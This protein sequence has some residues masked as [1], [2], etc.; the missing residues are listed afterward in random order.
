[1][2]SASKRYI[3][4]LFKRKQRASD[5]R[6]T[7]VCSAAPFRIAVV[8]GTGITC[9]YVAVKSSLIYVICWRNVVTHWLTC[10]RCCIDVWICI[11]RQYIQGWNLPRYAGVTSITVVD[12]KSNNLCI[13]KS[14]FAD[15]PYTKSVIIGVSLAKHQKVVVLCPNF[16]IFETFSTRAVGKIFKVGFT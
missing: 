6:L 15:Y 13:I 11:T 4:R 8:M 10:K 9:G 12:I 2:R 7:A 1:M 5:R 3:W 14:F 16:E